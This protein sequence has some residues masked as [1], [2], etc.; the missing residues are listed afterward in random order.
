ML[1]SFRMTNAAQGHICQQ[2]R[3]SF[4]FMSC[5]MTTTQ[6]PNPLFNTFRI[7]KLATQHCTDQVK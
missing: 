5:D 7:S 1:T 6:S 2:T 3:K 4:F